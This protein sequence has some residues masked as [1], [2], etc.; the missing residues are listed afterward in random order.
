[1][2]TMNSTSGQARKFHKAPDL[3]LVV[4]FHNEERY[5]PS[6]IESLQV[7]SVQNV[8]V[9]FIDNA[10]TDGSAALVQRCQEVRTGKW[11]CIEERKVGKVYAVKTATAFCMERLGARHVGFLDADSYCADSN[12]V[13]NSL[14][15]VDGA[16]GR[17]GYAYSPL[18]YFGFD[19]LPTFKSAYLAYEGVL[20]FLVENV[21]WSA[22]GLG[23]V[24]SA[25]LLTRY[26]ESAQITTEFDLRCSLLAL[27]D[28]RRAH[29][30]PAPL[31]TSGR[32]IIV[33]A[34]NFASWCFYNR[35]FYSKKD[36]NAETKVDLNTPTPVE[37]LQPN[38]IGEFF[39]RRAMKITCRH[40]IPLA[41]FDRSSFFCE[42]IRW[43]LGVDLTEECNGPFR[44]FP[45]NTEFLLT[46]RF[47]AMIRAIERNPASAALATPIE[48]L[49]RERFSF[50]QS[51]LPPFTGVSRY[52]LAEGR[53]D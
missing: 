8:P 12:W 51:R 39:R 48:N 26:F 1:M 21:G 3:A 2:N 28:G 24:C 23:F 25:D 19:E 15:I 50:S 22:H 46:D 41:V 17:F 20:R 38:M 53:D 6:L 14:E 29:L 31:A 9:V 7:Q 16:D 33:N 49:M 34:K 32:R 45:E 13:R 52:E 43:I 5:L 40:L 11:T 30:N 35:E 4:P 18:V 44:R 27:S 36:I 10:S 42:K 47:E 37:D